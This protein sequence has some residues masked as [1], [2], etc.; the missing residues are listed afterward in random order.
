MLGIFP[1]TTGSQFIII[2]LIDG[3]NIKNAESLRQNLSLG[4]RMGT[5]RREGMITVSSFEGKNLSNFPFLFKKILHHWFPSALPL[6]FPREIY[7]QFLSLKLYLPSSKT[8]PP[9]HS[10]RVVT[11]AWVLRDTKMLGSHL[12]HFLPHLGITSTQLLVSAIQTTNIPKCGK[13][14]T[15]QGSWFHFS[16]LCLEK[17]SS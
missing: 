6:F 1:F 14:T 4:H 11:S 8:L 15:S 9:Y 10:Q 3:K 12:V 13:L 5:P 7:W 17:N 2:I 16:K